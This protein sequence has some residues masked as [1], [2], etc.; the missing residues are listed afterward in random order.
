MSMKKYYGIALAA[1][2]IIAGIIAF[3]LLRGPSDNRLEPTPSAELSTAIIGDGVKFYIFTSDG[4]PTGRAS[5]SIP[6]LRALG[7]ASLINIAVDLNNNGGYEEKEWIIQDMPVQA[8]E[9]WN[10]NF[11]F[12][13]P[14]SFS[15]AKR[16]RVVFG[17]E[18]KDME[19]AAASFDA[20]RLFDLSSVTNPEEAMKGIGMNV[21]HAEE[22]AASVTIPDVPDIAQRP[23]ECAPT[24]AANGLISL[25]Q[26]YG[27][28]EKL[29]GTEQDL[30]DELKSD[31]KWTAENGVLPDDFVTGKN[32][33]AKRK[34]FFIRTEKVGDKHGI[35]TV[36]A[37]EEALKTDPDKKGVELR[38]KFGD[39]ATGKAVG[40]HMVS[41]TGVH[42]KNGKTY[43]DIHD[44]ASPDG[45]D[46]V[47]IS[48][49]QFANYG[50][51]GGWTIMSWGFI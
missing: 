37:I 36:S 3:L 34:G 18:E 14:D 25:I 28:L 35:D 22:G 46:T 21:A 17:N 32:A 19:I 43:L 11:Y 7:S 12:T 38:L 47:E 39:P 2:I 30:I 13:I 4:K 20:G 15:D 51:F 24:T 9:N 33:W 1:I 40:G 49:N 45:T 42:K 5:V 29:S 44:P 27:D 31:M 6:F 41:V 26:K 8:K 50:L 16:A 10:N 23:G 48:G